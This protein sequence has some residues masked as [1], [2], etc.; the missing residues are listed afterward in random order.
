LYFKSSS[1]LQCILISDDIFQNDPDKVIILEIKA[2]SEQNLGLLKEALNDYEKVNAISNNVLLLYRIAFLQYKLK[3]FGECEKSLNK[4]LS[5]PNIEKEKI[6]ITI[7]DGNQQIV[8]LKAVALN[9]K[10][11]IYMDMN[12]NDK[13]GIYFSEALKISPDFVLARDNLKSLKK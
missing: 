5:D 11:V 3:R 2:I 12:E 6:D 10:G 1:F 4:I 13:A 7:T 8:L 9:M